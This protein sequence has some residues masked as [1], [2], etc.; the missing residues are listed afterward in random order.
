MQ[1]QDFLGEQHHIRQGEEWQFP[2]G[3]MGHGGNLGWKRW[4]K[5][6]HGWR[7]LLGGILGRSSSHR[8][9]GGVSWPDPQLPPSGVNNQQVY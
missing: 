9:A 5:Q 6:R 2:H 3:Q 4:M 1:G 8:A 7:K